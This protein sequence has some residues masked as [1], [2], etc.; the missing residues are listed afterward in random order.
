M[1]A[2]AASG[3][4]VEKCCRARISVG[5]INAA[6]RPASITR[7]GG[8]QRDQR[9]ARADVAMQKPQHAVGLRQVGD[10]VGDGALLRR[11][12]R[13]GQGGDDFLRAAGPRRR[14]RARRGCACARAGAQARAGRPA[15]RRRPAATR[16]RSR[17]EVGRRRRAMHAAQARRRS[18]ESRCA[19]AMRRPAIPA[20]RGTRRARV[21][22]PCAA[23]SVQPF[24]ERIDRI[25]QRQLGKTGRI[26]HAVGMHHLQMAVIER[27]DAGDVAGLAFGKSFSK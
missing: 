15:V 18:P 23:G 16:P 27:G 20:S 21:R 7:R 22:S 13:I 5:A 2:A 6:C 17:L 12:Q 3:A 9:L 24:G 11:R 8:E 4:M 26:D 10:D 14:C 25:D 1:P 19:R